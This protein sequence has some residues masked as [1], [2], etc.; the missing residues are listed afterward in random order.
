[1]G[2]DQLIGYLGATWF[3][4][5]REKE[6]QRRQA[7]AASAIVI[8]DMNRETAV[9]KYIAAQGFDRAR[10]RKLE[11]LASSPE[12]EDQDE[13]TKLLGRPYSKTDVAIARAI[14]A[15]ADKEGW[16]YYDE[17]MLVY[18]PEYCRLK[19]WPPVDQEA[20]DA[21]KKRRDRERRNEVRWLGWV[22]RNPGCF[23]FDVSPEYYDNEERFALG[24]GA[25]HRKWCKSTF[26]DFGVEPGNY[27]TK[28][29]YERAL[30]ERKKELLDYQEA[31]D[32]LGITPWMGT[33]TFCMTIDRL[34]AEVECRPD[35]V[36]L[37]IFFYLA[38]LTH[39]I[40]FLGGPMRS[41]ELENFHVLRV[42]ARQN[43][44]DLDEVLE[45]AEKGTLLPKGAKLLSNRYLSRYV[46]TS[47]GDVYTLRPSSYYYK[48]YGFTIEDFEKHCGRNPGDYFAPP[49]KGLPK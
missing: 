31:M 6:E 39:C 25:A 22:E 4:S 32:L 2:L 38:Y 5:A 17:D 30:E 3:M 41:W 42:L 7:A 49:I 12:Q 36:P 48:Q 45:K 26:N 34:K 9:L 37:E 27:K 18:D 29:A 14:R 44:V 35:K 24:I 16:R 15:I 43:G 20:I 8:A 28:A 19:G 11:A 1:M 40:P 13:V 47:G 10:Q 21:V 33:T 46:L 23:D